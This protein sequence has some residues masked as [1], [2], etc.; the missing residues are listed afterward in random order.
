MG[1]V[2][3]A[4]QTRPVRRRVALKIIK[5]GL[6]TRQV[7]ARLRRRAS[8]ACNDASPRTSNPSARGNDVRVLNSRMRER[9]P[10][11]C[12]GRSNQS[13]RNQS[14]MAHVT[15]LSE[16]LIKRRHSN[17]LRHSER[18]NH[19]INEV[20]HCAAE[21][22]QS[23]CEDVGLE[24][25]YA[26]AGDKL[27]EHIGDGLSRMLVK[28]FKDE[29]AF[30]Q[31]GRQEDKLNVALVAGPRRVCRRLSR[32][33]DGPAPNAGQSDWYRP[34]AFCSPRT[35]AT[36]CGFGR[37]LANFRERHTTSLF[38]PQCPFERCGSAVNADCGV[39]AFDGKCQSVARLD[40]KCFT[41]LTRNGGLSPACDGRR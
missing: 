39:V 24:K 38:T 32:V 13:R 36:Q 15:E 25:F 10:N 7:V 31:H 18:G 20:D 22:G 11:V 5:P 35:P 37:G 27:H 14:L 23:V 34:L 1:V 8:G 28:G 4:E 19:A 26:R 17:S 6:D 2:F 30:S 9:V 29:H 12:R 21:A 41:N 16:A 3:M 40:A 33:P